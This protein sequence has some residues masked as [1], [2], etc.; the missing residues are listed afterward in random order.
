MLT[1][2]DHQSTISNLLASQLKQQ[3]NKFATIGIR[4]ADIQDGKLSTQL[5]CFF[6][7][8]IESLYF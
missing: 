5:R 4:T 2:I 3:T 8:A 1:T 6:M 7:F